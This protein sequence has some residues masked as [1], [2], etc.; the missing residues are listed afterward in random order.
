MKV[1]CFGQQN[2]DHCWTG[3]QQLLTRLPRRGHRVLYVDPDWSFEP[4]PLLDE[5]RALDGRRQPGLRVV[6]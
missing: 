3:K 5:W 1:V 6:G 4:R 2:W